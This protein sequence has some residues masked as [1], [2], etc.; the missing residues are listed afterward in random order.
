MTMSPSLILDIALAAVCIFVIVK[1]SIKGFLKTILDI[2]RLVLSVVF[3]IMFRGLVAKLLNDLFMYNSVYNWVHGSILKY[4]DGAEEKISFVKIFESYPDFYG[5]VLTNFGLNYEDLQAQMENINEAT[6]DS[7]SKMISEPLA[8]MF[9]VLLSV[10]VIF[11]ISMIVL[12]FLFKLINKITKIKGINI[13]NRIL[14]VV[15]GATLSVIIVWGLSLIIEIL[16][17]TLGP[18]IPNVFNED[19]VRNSMVINLLRELGLLNILENLKSQ[20]MGSVS[21]IL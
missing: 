21:L 13:V 1:Y 19:L 8:N 10:L 16:V 7:L 18:M 11:I 20:V 3:A 2:A 17:G 6:A 9:S 5:K 14:C 12:H 15:L 4:L